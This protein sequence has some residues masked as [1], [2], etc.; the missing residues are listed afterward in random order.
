MTNNLARGGCLCGSVNYHFDK[1][2]VVSAHHCHCKDCQKSTGSGKATIV[3][4]PSSVL[5]IEGELKFYTV[6]GKDGSHVS[7]GF[8]PNCGSQLISFLEEMKEVKFIKAGS[9]NDSSWVKI[10]SSFWSSTARD[11]SPV[12]ENLINYSHNPD[13]S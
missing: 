12:D 7:R 6:T 13:N 3:L 8:C 1:T 5:I 4:V 10:N 9:L 11:W 2:D